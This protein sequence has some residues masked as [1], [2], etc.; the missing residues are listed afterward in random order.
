VD[1]DA[2]AV[3]LEVGGRSRAKGSV[4]EDAALVDVEHHLFGVFDGLGSTTQAA[5][6]ATL[7][8]AAVCAAYRH[9]RG[10]GLAAERTFLPLAVGGA[11]VLV[12]AALEDGL[13]TASVV[14]VCV[15][16]G[17]A[18]A[19]VCNLGDS[20]VYKFAGDALHQCTL[21][22]SIFGSDWDLQ[23]QLSEATAATGMLNSAY[24]QLRNVMD[25]AL[26][27]RYQ[28]PHVWEVPVDDGDLLLAVSDGVT[29]NLTF[30]ELRQLLHDNRAQPDYI[31]HQIVDAAHA[32]SHQPGHPRAKVDDITAVV[33]KVILDVPE[34]ARRRRRR[35]S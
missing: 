31:A 29:D 18:I 12:A 30:S 2:G 15:S 24:F 1:P 16:G 5:D 19:L 32:R 14:K 4:N 26:G 33:A 6:A 7:A 25:R 22:D 23:L 17:V 13:T 21:D 20:R 35:L 8:A 11:G 9:H 10:D 34:P 28:A 3:A 27:E